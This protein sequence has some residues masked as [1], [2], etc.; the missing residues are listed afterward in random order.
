MQIK[1]LHQSS[2][3]RRNL[4]LNG[5]ITPTLIMLTVPTLMM[6]LV[7]SA[8]P[9]VDGLFINNFG[10]TIAASAINYCIPVVNM[11]VALAQG[12]SVASMAIIGQ[13]NGRGE[14]KEA[15]RI[16]TQIFIFAF[17][18]GFLV[19][20]LL[21]LAAYPV[22]S[23]VNPE[24]SHN[25]FLY[26]ALN[27]IVIPFSF[28]ESIYNGIKNASGKPEA[29]FI[30]MV[31]MLILKVIFNTIFV[32][33]LNWGVIGTVAATFL[34]N[35]LISVWMYYELFIK[36]SPERLELKGFKFDFEIIKELFRIGIPSAISSLILNLGFFLINN[37]IEKYGP[38]YMNAQGIASNITTVCFNLPS[39]FS[40]SVTTMV[41]MNVGAGQGN[42]A[43]SSCIRG[44]ITSAITAAI[45]I[46]VVV[47]LSSNIT[48]LFTR[49]AGVLSIADR[50]LHIY[51]YSVIGFGV[52]MVEQG[53]FIGLGRTRVTLVMSLLRI[54]VLRYI[55]ILVT[56][57]LLGAYSVFWGNLFSNY[58][59]A[60]I[61][62][63]MILR[64]KWVSVLSHRD[65]ETTA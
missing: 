27:S 43:R 55:F 21:I 58:A 33:V 42:K 64:V 31:L 7:Q 54:W 25:V 19:A 11:S 30:R 37:E 39:S 35:V 5:P 50:A 12:L 20:P 46:A 18:L 26:L 14:F 41:S 45:L 24:I 23:H 60:L 4:I 40:S 13:T 47:P 51:T 61:F 16:S 38:V 59:A 10:G 15:R 36:K 34:S 17:L 9:F 56:E 1:F 29:T 8:I 65:A 2:E 48:V 32:A 28:L 52:S 3:E 53:A 22:S 57:H 63:I 44:C 49:D 62:T 6:G